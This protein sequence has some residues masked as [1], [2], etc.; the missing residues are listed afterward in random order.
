MR[1]PKIKTEDLLQGIVDAANGVARARVA[2]AV[3][4]INW[5]IAKATGR[6]DPSR[7]DLEAAEDA[8]RGEYARRDKELDAADEALDAAERKLYLQTEARLRADNRKAAE[9]VP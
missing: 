9:A 4:A 6:Q 3:A 2:R 5:D 1:K 7:P 8:A